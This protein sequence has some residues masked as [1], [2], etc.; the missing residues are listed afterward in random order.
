M[1]KGFRSRFNKAHFRAQYPTF[2]LLEI[3]ERCNCRCRM[4]R[5]W[6]NKERK[7]L[8]INDFERLFRDPLWRNLRILSLTGGEPFLRHD[9]IDIILLAARHLPRLERISFP[10]NGILTKHIM[11]TVKAIL[12]SLPA[13]IDFK[14]GISIDGVEDVHDQMRGVPGAYEKA[15]ETVRQLK[16]LNAPN[17]SVGILS[18]ITKETI[19]NLRNAHEIFKSLTSEITYTIA[20]Q[21]PFFGNLETDIKPFTSEEKNALIHFIN[22]TLIPE[23]P[24]KSYLYDKYKEHILKDKRTYPCLA[25]YLSA[26]VDVRGN[27]LP[28]HYVGDDFIITNIFDS[29]DTLEKAWFSKNAKAVRMRMEEHPYCDNCSN[30]CDS[31]NLIYEDFWDFFFYLLSHPAIPLAAFKKILK[32]KRK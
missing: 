24:E 18:L 27:L 17:F 11:D 3:T 31:R 19:P 32:S 6:E 30:N 26:Y 9:L 13:H 22:K 2:L 10:S 12:S 5:I 23:F 16:S 8:D 29:S 4:C 28:C 20:T 1:I 21:S 25:G 14:I 15:T 7:E